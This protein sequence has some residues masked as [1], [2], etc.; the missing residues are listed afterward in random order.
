MWLLCC[1]N[2]S[3]TM[4]CPLLTF[5][6]STIAL[7]TFLCRRRLFFG[8]DALNLVATFCLIIFPMVVFCVF[9]GRQL[10]TNF[11]NHWGIAIMVVSVVHTCAVSIFLL[12]FLLLRNTKMPLMLWISSRI[13]LIFHNYRST[14]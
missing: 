1:F 11:P 9:V 4:V 12:H 13:H 10:M 5:V 14:M 8:P 2:F 7:Q 3:N 6:L